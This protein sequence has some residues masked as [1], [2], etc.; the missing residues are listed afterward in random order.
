MPELNLKLCYNICKL[1]VRKFMK[2]AKLNSRKNEF[3]YI[4]LNKGPFY[5]LEKA[6]LW[7]TSKLLILRIEYKASKYE[8]KLSKISIGFENVLL[9]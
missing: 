5:L 1:F 3:L 9:V 2:T 8:H 7:N 6:I 4:K